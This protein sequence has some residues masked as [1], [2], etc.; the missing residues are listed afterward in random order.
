MRMK[1]GL[2]LSLSLTGKSPRMLTRPDWGSSINSHVS[3][4]IEPEKI[5]VRVQTDTDSL[6]NDI[7]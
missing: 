3:G 6:D 4:I 1:N 2:T 5:T 7:H